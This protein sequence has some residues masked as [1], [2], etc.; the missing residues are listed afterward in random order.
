M[1]AY[2]EQLPAYLQAALDSGVCIE[3]NAEVK[4]IIITCKSQLYQSLLEQHIE[5]LQAPANPWGLK[6][7]FGKRLEK[8]LE[9]Q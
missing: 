5:A 6:V 8:R 3:H 1:Q 7:C 4:Q 9:E 2:I